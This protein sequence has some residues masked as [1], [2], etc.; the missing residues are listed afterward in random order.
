MFKKFFKYTLFLTL[1]IGS[2]FFVDM[3]TP[4]YQTN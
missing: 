1:L 2:Y 3:D 4:N